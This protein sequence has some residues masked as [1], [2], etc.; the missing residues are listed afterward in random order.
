[1]PR[2]YPILNNNQK[3]ERILRVRDKGE[4]VPDLAK[5]YGVISKTIYNLLRRQIN[6]SSVEL[7]LSRVRREKDVLLKI[8]GELVYESKLKKKK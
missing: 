2:G 7:E 1:M 8:V 6:H 5:E 3:Q 4:R